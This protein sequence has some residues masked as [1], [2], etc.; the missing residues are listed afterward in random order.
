MLH[1]VEVGSFRGDLIAAMSNMMT[2]L[3]SRGSQPVISQQA[4]G[5]GTAFH[6]RFS[7]EREALP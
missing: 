6:L 2:W 4:A 1:T 3:H 5:Q 7:S